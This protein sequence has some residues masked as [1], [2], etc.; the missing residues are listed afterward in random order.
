VDNDGGLRTSFGLSADCHPTKHQPVDPVQT[1]SQ[2]LPTEHPSVLADELDV[3]MVLGPTICY[4]QHGAVNIDN[5]S[6]SAE[7]TAGDLM[8][9]CSPHTMGHVIPAA[10]SPPH[11]QRAHGLPQDLQ[12]SDEESA[13]PPAATGTEPAE[14]ARQKPLDEGVAYDYEPSPRRATRDTGSIKGWR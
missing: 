5:T 2:P 8:V 6:S 3:V 12:R 1:L 10:I 11:D 14:A 9:N 7:E 4:T 13:D